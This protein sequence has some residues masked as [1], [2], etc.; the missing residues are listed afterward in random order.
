MRIAIIDLGTNSVRFDIHQFGPGNRL[1]LLHREKIMIRLGQGVFLNG[2]LDKRAV[3]RTLH[4]FLKFKQNA[5][6]A[7][8]QK[9]IAFGTSALR[10]V[11]D[12]DRFV[13]LIQER[14]GIHVRV[15]SGA[16]EAKLIALGILANEETPKGRYALVDIGGGSTEVSICSGQKVLHSSSF[17]LGTARLQQM[18]LKKSPPSSASIENLRRHIRNTFFQVTVSERWPKVDR[19]IGSSGTIKALAKIL[20]KTKHTDFIE[21]ESLQELVNQLTSM[22]TPEL[23]KIPGMEAKRVD[24]ILAG[25]VL[26]DET[27]TILNAKKAVPTEYSL[28]DGILKEELDLYRKGQS[29]HISLHLPELYQMAT[30]FGEQEEHL[31]SMVQVAEELFVQLK[32]LHKMK[33]EWLIY[34]TAATILRDTGEA[35]S[36]SGHEQHSYYIA[37]HADLPPTEEWEIELIAQL[38]RYHEGLKEEIKEAPFPNN[39]ERRASFLKLLSLLRIVDALDPAEFAKV[40][41][42]RVKIA[43]NQVLIHY[44][45]RHLSGLETLN[46]ELAKGLFQ[47]LFKRNL[48]A[49]WV[50][51]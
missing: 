13:E 37:K 1:R 30:R 20:R 8:V 4:V 26:F 16:E 17:P 46:V 36:L 33:P 27:M 9:I 22:P 45:G 19:V 11:R 47:R 2:R 7:R 14:S 6:Q 43:R 40:Q 34:L 38:C 18:F 24:M 10:E 29:S 35:I 31:R 21:P 41:V 44:S 48:V 12:R 51:K 15:I 50:S 25:A 32:P 49:E 42:K 5:E 3:Q 39:R 23:L 28:R